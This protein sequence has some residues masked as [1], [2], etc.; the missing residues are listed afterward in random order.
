MPL[1]VLVGSNL[2]RNE[3]TASLLEKEGYELVRLPPAEA[4]HQADTDL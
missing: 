4:G 2:G 3:I 1:K